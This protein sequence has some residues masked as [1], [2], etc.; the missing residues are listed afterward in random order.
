M[1]SFLKYTLA[2]IV[3]ILIS[4]FII[5]ILFI[6]IISSV[7]TLADQ[8]VTV[9][10]KSVLIIRLDGEILERAKK[11][12]FDE[13]NIPGLQTVKRTGLDQVLAC[14]KKAKN[15]N[16]IEG[17]YLNP[18]DVSAGLATLEEI[19]NALIDFKTSG[20]FVYAYGEALSQKAYYLVS[21]ADKVV[22]NPKGMVELKGLSV[23]VS[24]FKKVLKKIGVE[25]QVIRHGKFKAAVEPYI[26]DK[27]S[28]ENRL[29][30]K[31]YLGSL[32]GQMLDDISVSRNIT[33]DKLNGLA[34]SVTTFHD[35]DFL[36]QNG[37]VDTLEYKD[38]VIAD[39]KELIG[40]REQSDIRAIDIK[41]YAKAPKQTSGSFARDKVAVI[42]ASGGI[43]MPG[44]SSEKIDS[45][46]LSR[47]IR[48]ARRDTSVKA[49]VLRINSPGGSAYGAE[50]IWREV[51]LA[52]E[53][54]PVV[55]SMGDVAASGGYYIAAAADSVLAERTTIT[56][57]IGIF[58]VIPNIGGLLN[59]KL[60]I[61]Q[62][63]VNTNKHSDILSLTRPMTG[64]ERGVMQR[65][66]EEGYKTFTSRVA[67]GR[68]MTRS[69][70]DSVGQGRVWAA[71]NAIQVGLVDR[72]GS[73]D[74]AVKM[75]SRMAGIKRFRVVPLP[76]LKDPF[77]SWLRGISDDV[78][79]SFMK[80]ELGSSYSIYEQL[81]QVKQTRGILARVPYDFQIN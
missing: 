57:S 8:P 40:T 49:I 63:V 72:Y 61:T 74:D 75:A 11:N 34:D 48:K 54:K 52:A 73:I 29:Q 28:P 50:V 35:A 53:A 41:D 46:K 17:I 66:I 14:I 13:L 44:S 23:K 33:V 32:W 43:D 79:T 68:G 65:Y 19:R 2:T 70:V 3:G 67:E 12:P 26:K 80:E 4:G 62:D 45:Q 10:N 7:A 59:D 69:A 30:T 21:A 37:L 20:K 77:E 64:F 51:K 22:L 25:M 15:N 47:T 42:Y 16:H 18:S 31:K 5:T 9:K 56:G 24:F 36:V 6:G 58:G 71:Q 1:K 38:E 27:M 60:G 55:A 39:L 78:K 76:K 81:N